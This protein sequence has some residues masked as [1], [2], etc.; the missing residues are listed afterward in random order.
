MKTVFLQNIG[1]YLPTSPHGITI[2]NTNSD[3]LLEGGRGNMAWKLSC[4]EVIFPYAN[5]RV[6]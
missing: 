4:F 5:M 1:I 3:E 2:H 6:N